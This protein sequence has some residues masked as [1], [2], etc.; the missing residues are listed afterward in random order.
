MLSLFITLATIFVL[1]NVS[2]AAEG[3]GIRFWNLTAATITSLQLSPAG[4]GEWGRN[5][6]ENDKDHTVD[7]DER[8][9]ITGIEPGVYDVKFRDMHR[10]CVIKNIDI[11]AGGI[12]SIEEEK[13][14]GLCHTF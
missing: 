2:N 13:L 8:L 9:K 7:H 1:P 6:T 3:K 4:K 12:F 14:A 10:E 11:K 5:Q